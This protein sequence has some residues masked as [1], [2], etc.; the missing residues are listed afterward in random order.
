MK[1]SLI[2]IVVV[3]SSCCG[4]HTEVKYQ[5]QDIVITRIDECGETNFYYGDGQNDSSGR[6]WVEYS[7]INDGFKGYLKFSKNGKVVILSGDGYFQT[8][9]IDTSRFEYRRIAAFERPEISETVCYINLA[10]KFEQEDNAAEGSGVK[11][12]YNIDDN[13][14]W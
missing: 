6:V 12:E 3:L 13:E 1:C 9:N 10:T 4:L 7:G 2:L 11:A 14:W 5:Y 8:E